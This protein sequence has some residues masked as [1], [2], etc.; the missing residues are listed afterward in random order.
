MSTPGVPGDAVAAGLPPLPA[1]M[2]GHP[3]GADE[4]GRP[5]AHV[6]GPVVVG[7]VGYMLDCVAQRTAASLPPEIGSAEREACIKQ[8]RQISGAPSCS[9]AK[10]TAKQFSQWIITRH[11]T[12]PKNGKPTSR[13]GPTTGTRALRSYMPSTT[14][15]TASSANPI[16]TNQ[17]ANPD[18]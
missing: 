7:T 17:K 9:A 6:K 18:N 16:T 1:Y 8:V 14:V 5:I 2:V 11:C 15:A 4:A 13:A 10:V 12:L 3:F